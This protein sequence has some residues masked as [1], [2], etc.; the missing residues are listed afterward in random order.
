M[1][2]KAPVT[3]LLVPAFFALSGM[4]T[5]IDLVS[6]ASDWLICGAIILVAS[7]GKFGGCLI[8]ARATGMNGRD[9]A[10]LAVLMNTRGLMEL[11]VLNIGLSLGV[12]TPRLFTMMVLMA[13]AT[14]MVASPVL[15]LVVEDTEIAEATDQHGGPEER[16][17]TEKTV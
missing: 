16:R 9:S 7:V 4:R 6:G 5:R 17:R 14:T 12:V 3:I 15:D 1:K 11:I 2:L 8:A 10:A 13:L